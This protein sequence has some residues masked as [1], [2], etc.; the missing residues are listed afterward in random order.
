VELSDV[1]GPAASEVAA[2]RS[3]PGAREGACP[4]Y[5][6]A[7]CGRDAGGS[8]PRSTPGPT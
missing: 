3:G 6:E 5:R 2:G 7:A 8:T 4:G 1:V